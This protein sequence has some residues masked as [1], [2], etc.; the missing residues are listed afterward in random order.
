MHVAS[1]LE[2]FFLLPDGNSHGFGSY[3]REPKKAKFPFIGKK[4]LIKNKYNFLVIISCIYK[5]YGFLKP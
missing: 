1:I 5:L 2:H 3:V 4:F